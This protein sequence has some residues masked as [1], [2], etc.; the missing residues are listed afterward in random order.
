[1]QLLEKK[2][3]LNL[4]LEN[5]AIVWFGFVVIESVVLFCFVLFHLFLYFFISF[6]AQ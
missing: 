6:T 5:T 1:M 4:P 3:I 2:P